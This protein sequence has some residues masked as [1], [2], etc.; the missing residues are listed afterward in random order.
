MKPGNRPNA[1]SGANSS[2]TKVS[3]DESLVYNIPLS[4]S[5]EV[6]L[7]FYSLLH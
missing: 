1:C 6:F 7:F 2:D 4:L 5:R 3:T